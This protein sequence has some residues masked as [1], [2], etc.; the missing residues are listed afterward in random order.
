MLDDIIGQ[1]NIKKVLQRGV[2]AE[3]LAHAYLFWAAE[4]MGKY[5]L[6]HRFAK[7]LL[8]TSVNP[9]C[10]TCKAC[11]LFEGGTLPDFRVIEKLK[12]D[13]EIKIKAIRD[14]QEEVY[15]KPVYSHKKVYIIRDADN[16]NPEA[17]NCLLKTLE[18]PPHYI[19]IILT[20]S[21]VNALLQTVRSRVVRL[22]FEPYS[23]EEFALILDRSD[24]QD[25]ND[26]I[27]FTAEGIPGRA[28]QLI[29]GKNEMTVRDEA[30]EMLFKLTEDPLVIYRIHS[31]MENNKE[32]IDWILDTMK[33]IMRDMLI[34]HV[35]KKDE[36]LL[37]LDKKDMIILYA[38]KW[39][40]SSL[41]GCIDLIEE[42]KK[43][44]KAKGNYSI[45][46]Q[47]MLLNIREECNL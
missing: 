4:G 15:T 32:K 22:D 36:L 33:S 6:A 40:V 3:K 34:C 27:Y 25:V 23:K 43:S 45:A 21:N 46:T 42:C 41:I 29:S 39:K 5:T 9:P 16:M 37:N 44:L 12:D 20:A 26:F 30:A 10:G 19:H 14:M 47:A 8:C 38:P 17:Q 28:I 11:K 1:H 13:K 35:N 31:F 18:E 2:A 24:K 7:A